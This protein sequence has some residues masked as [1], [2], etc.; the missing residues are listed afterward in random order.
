MGSPQR[1]RKRT[2]TLP[3]SVPVSRLQS[4]GRR[5]ATTDSG[6]Q[7]RCRIRAV[8][9]L[10]RQGVRQLAVRKGL[11]REQ[12]KERQP[13]ALERVGGPCEVDPPDAKLFLSNL[14]SGGL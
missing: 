4:N 10:A 14:A 1:R 8:H 9:V 12:L 5:T 13:A 7:T 3:M 6:S 11:A 2:D